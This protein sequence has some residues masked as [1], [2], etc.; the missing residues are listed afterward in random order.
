MLSLL[1]QSAVQRPAPPNKPLPPDPA[2]SESK[3]HRKV[4]TGYSHVWP[5]VPVLHVAEQRVLTSHLTMSIMS[6]AFCL[7]PV[8]QCCVA[9][10]WA[11]CVSAC[12]SVSRL[13]FS[14]V[15]IGLFKAGFLSSNLMRQFSTVFLKDSIEHNAVFLDCELKV[16]NLALSE[17]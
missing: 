13:L 12:V 1:P 4:E 9:C 17:Y 3:K 2:P 11:V 8:V 16:R 5:P 6:P 14:W 10:A 7:Q 15:R